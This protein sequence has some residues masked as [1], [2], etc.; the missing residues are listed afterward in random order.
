[1]DAAKNVFHFDLRSA[2]KGVLYEFNHKEG[3]HFLFFKLAEVSVGFEPLLEPFLRKRIVVT[4]ACFK[5][6]QVT[7]KCILEPGKTV[8][9]NLGVDF[10][11]FSSPRQDRVFDDFLEGFRV[12]QKALVNVLLFDHIDFGPARVYPFKGTAPDSGSVFF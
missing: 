6:V 1:M 4:V 5:G 3:F 8:A 9:T 10:R 2:A 12:A 7:V 11:D